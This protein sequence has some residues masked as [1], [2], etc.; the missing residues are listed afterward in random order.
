MLGLREDKYKGDML[1]NCETE[2][3]ATGWVGV[4]VPVCVIYLFM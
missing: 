2:T 1:E 4:G 3:A